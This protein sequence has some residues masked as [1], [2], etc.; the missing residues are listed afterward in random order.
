[1][2]F[3]PVAHSPSCL[4]HA[5]NA[6]HVSVKGTHNQS[7]MR[8]YG[9]HASPLRVIPYAG[10][11]IGLAAH[12][13]PCRSRVLLSHTVHHVVNG[14]KAS[15]ACSIALLSHTNVRHP[16]LP[17]LTSSN[18]HQLLPAKPNPRLYSLNIFLHTTVTKLYMIASVFS[19]QCFFALSLL[20]NVFLELLQL[21]LNFFRHAP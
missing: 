19:I 8:A 18:R 12:A 7:N 3:A 14:V 13:Y 21:K 15:S 2:R 11:A 1:M 10:D 9:H 17:Q 20:V 6:M 16:R 4:S 5:H